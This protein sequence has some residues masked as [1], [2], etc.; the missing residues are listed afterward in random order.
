MGKKGHNRGLQ[1]TYHS[2]LDSA[3]QAIVTEAIIVNA[4]HTQGIHDLHVTPVNLTA[5]WLF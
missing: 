1:E 4:K 5:W 3:E 2:L